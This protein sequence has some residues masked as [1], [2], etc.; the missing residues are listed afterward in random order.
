MRS[1]ESTLAQARLVVPESGPD[2][3]HERREA[4][5]VEQRAASEVGDIRSTRRAEFGDTDAARRS[6]GKCDPHRASDA[7]RAVVA[8]VL[9]QD[10][11]GAATRQEQHRLRPS[12]AH[13]LIAA[14][15]PALLHHDREQSAPVTERDRG[16]P[17]E[18]AGDAAAVSQVHRKGVLTRGGAHA[19]PNAQRELRFPTDTLAGI[20]G[21][22]ARRQKRSK[23]RVATTWTG[24]LTSRTLGQMRQLVPAA[25]RGH[26]RTLAQA[27]IQSYGAVTWVGDSESTS[28]PIDSRRSRPSNE[29][30]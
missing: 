26:S 10:N 24:R 3:R 28:T 18:G 22:P 30:L 8:A 12:H 2:A 25:F 16:I 4:H 9:V 15:V 21:T 23:S 5:D 29:T 7:Q 17:V 14:V 20:R 11:V 1:G 6:A 19:V 27:T 13:L